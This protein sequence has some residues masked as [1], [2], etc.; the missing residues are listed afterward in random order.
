MEFEKTVSSRHILHNLHSRSSKIKSPNKQGV[1]HEM[2]HL[3]DKWKPLK[4][5]KSVLLKSIISGKPAMF[6]CM[7]KNIE[8]AQTGHDEWNQKKQ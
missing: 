2:S 5:D 4:V 1:V 8:I 3:I 6:Q 7:S